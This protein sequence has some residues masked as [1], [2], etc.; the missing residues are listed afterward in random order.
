ML[1]NSIFATGDLDKLKE[2]LR[3][4]NQI[5]ETKID[6]MGTRIINKG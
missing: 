1:G 4:Y 6:K 2:I 3:P 5:Y